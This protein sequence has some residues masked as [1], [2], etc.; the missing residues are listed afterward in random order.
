MLEKTLPDVIADELI[1]RI[2]IGQYPAGTRLP[3][4]RH[5]C[6]E[7]GVDRTSLRMALR[8]LNRM[9][10]IQSVRGSGITVMDHRKHAGLDFLAAIFAIPQLELGSKIKM[11][12]LQAFNALIPGLMYDAISGPMDVAL[13]M[14]MRDLLIEQVRILDEGTP[15]SQT[16]DRLAMLELGLQDCLLYGKSMITELMANSTKSLRSHIMRELFEH[17]DIRDHV[18]RQYQFILDVGSGRIPLDQFMSVFHRYTL[19]WTAPL[20]EHYKANE[21]PPRLLESPLSSFMGGLKMVAG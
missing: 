16:R 7:L 12:G 20:I 2:F 19:E 3:A 14:K 15:D 10:L 1:A 8:A 21:V 5:F 13:A 17:I 9:N 18:M 4:E 6:E 11:Q